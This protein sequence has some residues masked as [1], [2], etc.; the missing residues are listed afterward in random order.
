MR[1]H[2]LESML[3]DQATIERETQEKIEVAIKTLRHE[4]NQ[5]L[6]QIEV[7]RADQVLDKDI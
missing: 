5:L 4:N 1:I 3:K 6:E 7:Y 2:E